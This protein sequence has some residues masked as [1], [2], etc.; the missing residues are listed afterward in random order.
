MVCNRT[1]LR[2]DAREKYTPEWCD[3]YVVGN[4]RILTDAVITNWLPPV[5]QV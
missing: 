3:R 1:M 2:S 5:D 4:L